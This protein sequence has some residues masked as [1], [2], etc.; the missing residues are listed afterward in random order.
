MQL[1]TSSELYF[2]QHYTDVVE[3]DEFLS[4]SSEEMVK[5]ISS[6]E[7]IVPSEEKIFESVIRWIKRDL[8]SRKQI[9]HQLMEHVRLPLISKDY[10]L[11]NVVDEPLLINCSKCKDYVFEALRFNLLRSEELIT[12]P[13]N[14]RT[15]PRQPGGTHKVILAVGGEGNEGTLVSTEW[16]DPTINQWQPGPKMITP[17]LGGGLAV[18]NDNFAIHLG[19]ENLDPTFQSG[20]GLDLS[21]ESPRWKP[22]YNMLVKREL[23]GVSVINNCIYV[24]SY[25]EILLITLLVISVK[26]KVLT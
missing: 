1:S 4:L 26:M 25:I 20:R 13:H 17:S 5:L 16:Y 8:D 10:I 21:S 14:I 2:H 3:G 22:T 15:K 12:I 18:V 23:F 24:V 9:L 19:G 6:D 11:K 7:L